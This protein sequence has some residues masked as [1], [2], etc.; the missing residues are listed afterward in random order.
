MMRRGAGAMLVA[1]VMLAPG[2]A[3]AEG[4]EAQAGFTARIGGAYEAEITGPGVLVYLPTGGWE[5]KGAYFVADAQGVR[6]HGITFVLPA[7]IGPGRHE[8]QNPTPFELGTVVSVR[9]DR[10]V[11]GTVVSAQRDTS[12][13]LDLDSFPD[14]AKEPNGAAVSASF[15]FE[16]E[17]TDGARIG[18]EGAFSFSY[19]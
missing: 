16:T 4:E 7:D 9:V 5:R 3:G 6:P 12:G 13:Y 19:R 18:A 15:A 8:L 17:F 1:S 14:G 2:A 10:D 11:D